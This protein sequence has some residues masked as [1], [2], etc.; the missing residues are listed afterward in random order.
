MGV[1]QFDARPEGIVDESM[2]R[3]NADVGLQARTFDQGMRR[4]KKARTL[5]AIIKIAID[6]MG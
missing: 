3:A 4:S 2:D 1:G 5:Y 6:R